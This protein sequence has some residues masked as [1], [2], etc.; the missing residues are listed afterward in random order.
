MPNPK[1][2]KK[3]EKDLKKAGKSAKKIGNEIADKIKTIK[4]KY[5]KLDNATKKQ[6][7]TGLAGLAALVVG[8]AAVK[9]ATKKN[10]K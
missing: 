4:G 9:K 6:I 10:K 7:I 8:A 2:V 1:T 5:D 3:I